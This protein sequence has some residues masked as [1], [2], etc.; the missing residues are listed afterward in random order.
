MK[1][2]RSKVCPACGTR[3]KAKWEFCVRCGESIQS[4]EATDEGTAPKAQAAEADGVAAAEE[5]SPLGTGIALLLMAA[6][7]AVVVV[8]VQNRPAPENTV[9]P[10]AFQIATLPPSLPAA[11]APSTTPGSADVNAGRRLLAQN[12]HAGAAAAF[13]RALEKLP[14][15]P[16]LHSLYAQALLQQALSQSGERDEALRHFEEAARLSPQTSYRLGFAAALNIAGRNQDAIAQYEQVLSQEPRDQQALKELGSLYNRMGKYEEAATFLTRAAEVNPTDLALQQ[17]LAWANEAKGNL[18]Q[19]AETYRKV[20]GAAPGAVV[21]RT[22]LAEVLVKQQKAEEALAL[23]EEGLRRDP[24]VPLLRRAR[25]SL[26]ERTGKIAEAIAEYREYARIT[27][28]ADDARVVMER[29]KQ[30]E[31]LAAG[32]SSS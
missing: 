8:W 31:K 28:N 14:S 2:E 13:A 16:E 10:G 32:G 5:R 22:R 4:V 12:N 21:S 1:Q 6:A 29:A 20:L 23:V 11:S 17:D 26:L 27:S 9:E 19:A 24:A 18:D 3:N 25:A 15:D 7:V 30:L